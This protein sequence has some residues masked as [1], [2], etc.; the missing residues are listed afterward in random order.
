MLKT[1]VQAAQGGDRAAFQELV[2]RF[3]DMAHG[4]AYS[5][6]R[7]RDQAQDVTQEAF[8]DVLLNINQLAEPEAFPGWFR[9]ILYKHCDRVRRRPVSVPLEIIP[10]V[11]IDGSDPLGELERKEE[12]SRASAALQNLPETTRQVV[13]LKYYA[14][15]THKEIAEFLGLTTTEVNNRLYG[16]RN[17]VRKEL[18]EMAEERLERVGVPDATAT[19]QAVQEQVD[20]IKRVH[21]RLVNPVRDILKGA[22]K[23]DVQIEMESVRYLNAVEAIWDFPNPCC[24]YSFTFGDAKQNLILEFGM[25][26]AAAVGV[27]GVQREPPDLDSYSE[28]NS[29]A[30]AMLGS[31]KT[32]W[33]G[34]LEGEITDVSLETGPIAMAAHPKLKVICP[35]A[36]MYQ[37][38]LRV[39][40][41]ENRDTLTLCYP[42]EALA[43]TC[44]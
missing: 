40:W 27:R 42:E 26:L 6:L 7:N 30:W 8:V 11:P 3:Q 23:A 35:D 34:V 25:L 19:S 20:V 36:S 16:G 37:A 9:T 4:Y 33:Q 2:G 31:L 12:A 21:S 18:L 10:Q 13:V 39:T 22:L 29:V 15:C 43:T 17:L 38:I 28:A 41:G 14:C 1:L 24:A 44:Q 32:A 5:Q